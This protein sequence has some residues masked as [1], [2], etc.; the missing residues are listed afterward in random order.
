M[1]GD[2]KKPVNLQTVADRVGLAPCSVSAVLNDTPAAKAIP[3]ATKDRVFRAAKELN[4]RPNLW[5]RSLRTKRTRM[6]AA[7]TPDFGHGRVA[8]VL[9]GLQT[10]LQQK[11]YL[12]A[13]TGLDSGDGGHLSAHYRQRGIEGVIAINATFPREFE[14][15]VASVDLGYVTSSEPME[16]GLRI[17]LTKMGEA[18][19]D[20]IVRNIENPEA[21]ARSRVEPKL[22]PAYF[23]V[24]GVQ[25]SIEA[26]E[27]A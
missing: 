2:T 9:A 6:V 19:A 22:P 14:L 4:Y 3:Q 15:P 18:A 26:R 17:W 1:S 24:S 7:V 20:M 5:A 12:L 23:D 8:Q 11:G 21:S 13:L 16:E 10:R 27:S 25:A